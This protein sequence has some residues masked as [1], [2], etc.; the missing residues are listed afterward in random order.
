MPN[1]DIFNGDADG[2]CAIHQ[3]RLNHPQEST[4]VTGVKRDT[5]LL[6]KVISVKNSVLTVL[7]I[8]SHANRDSLLQLLKQGNTIHYYD[9]HLSGEIPESTLFHPH[10]DTNP[11]VCTSI[12]VDRF[13]K[14]DHRS[15]AIVASFGDNLHSSALKLADSLNLDAKE[16]EELREMGELIN[17]NSYGET[18]EDLYFSPEFLYSAINP[19]YDPLE[20]FHSSG[21]LVKLREGFLNDMELA[22]ALLPVRDCTAGRI[23][24][25][26]NE[27]WCRRVCGT[28]INKLAREEPYLAHSLLVER[29]DGT[30]QISVRAPLAKPYGAEKLCIKFAGG[31]RAMAAGINDLVPEEVELFFEAFE[32]QFVS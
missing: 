8:S 18:K 1:F 32:K 9:H 13:L 31:G 11:E 3:I 5:L 6:K 27:A 17:Y 12:I 20:F 7:D 24:I 4:L 26:P 23:F 2:I 29:Q 22:E 19:Y 28:F 14:G 15:W 10:I 21:E 30:F 16:I 25:F